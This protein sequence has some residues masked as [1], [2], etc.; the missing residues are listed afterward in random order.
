MPYPV[1]HLIEGRP[2]PVTI[3]LES[4]IAWAL[5]VMQD[6]DFSQLPVVDADMRPLGL[7]TTES[8]LRAVANFGV[9]AEDLYAN[10]AMIRAEK[11]GADD[12]LFDLLDRLRNSGGVLV[13]DGEGTLIGIVTNYD[14]NEYFRQR[15]EDLMLIEDIESMVKDLVLA[16]FIGDSGEVDQDAV[17][18]AVQA[19]TSSRPVPLGASEG[20]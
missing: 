19:L 7:V 16:A 4:G 5:D 13:V 9:R 20:L 2:S 12:D 3:R 10:D 11:L 17:L 8:I 18:A 6:K 15:T 14:A 1:K